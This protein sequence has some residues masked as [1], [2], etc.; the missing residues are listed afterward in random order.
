MSEAQFP[1]NLIIKS[2]SGR[3]MGVVR[4]SKGP[5]SGHMKSWSSAEFDVESEVGIGGKKASEITSFTPIDSNISQNL[6]LSKLYQQY[7]KF[8]EVLEKKGGVQVSSSDKVIGFADK[9]FI[10]VLQGYA[11]ENFAFQVFVD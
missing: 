10:S 3:I 11:L 6:E 1:V 5:D 8:I 7:E 4:I 2:K 9:K